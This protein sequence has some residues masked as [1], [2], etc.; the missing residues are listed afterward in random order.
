[1]QVSLIG[2]D[3]AKSVFQICGVNQ[4]GKQVFNRAIKRHQM[5]DFLANQPDVPVA[6][7]ACSGS[8]YWGRTLQAQGRKV[9][10]IPPQHV[11]PFVKGNKNDRNDAFAIT[12]A[13]RRP[14]MRFVEP[15]SLEQTDILVLHKL[16]NRKVQART[17]LINQIRGFL[18]EYGVIVAPGKERLLKALPELLEDAENPLTCAAREALQSLLEEWREANRQIQ[19]HEA[20]LKQ[21]AKQLEPARRLMGVKGVAEKT[22]TAV[23]AYAGDGKAFKSGRHFAANLGL[24]PNEHSSGGKQKLGRITRRGNNYLRRLLVQGA[25][26]V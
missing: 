12:E 3:L 16:I 5:L 1:M 20:K 4:A 23:V 18:N 24:V 19:M 17:A 13:A 11:K 2:I 15:R 9:L 7:E 21:T 25:W 10:L 8:N 26:S 14:R 22:A 6:M